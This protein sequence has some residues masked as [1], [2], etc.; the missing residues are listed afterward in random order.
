MLRARSAP[1]RWIF[2][3]PVVLLPPSSAR[4]RL[5]VQVRRTEL[6]VREAVKDEFLAR[7]TIW[8]VARLLQ[9][10]ELMRHSTEEVVDVSLGTRGP[11]TSGTWGS[12]Y[13]TLASIVGHATARSI[14]QRASIN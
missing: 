2:Y 5:D 13:G 9:G 11:R 7:P 1:L 14:V 4:K 10:A 8:A 3:T 6:L 12:H